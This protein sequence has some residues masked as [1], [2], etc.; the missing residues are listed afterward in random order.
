MEWSTKC[1][2]WES[3]VLKGESLITFPPLFPLEADSA[4]AVFKELRLVDVLNRPTLGEAGRQ[5]LFDFVGAIFGA[6]DPEGGRRLIQEFFLLISKKN[7]KSTGASAIMLTALIR[8]WRDSAEFLIL[9]PTV[10]IANN[11]F[12]PA[13]DMV[14]A[15]GELSDLFLVQ[16]HYRQITHRTT[17]AVLK[18]VAADSET[19]GGKKATGILIDEAWLM[20]KRA[21]AENMLRE[22]CGGLA[23]RPEGFIIYLSTQSDE[24]PAGVFKQMTPDKRWT[25]YQRVCDKMLYPT[26]ETETGR[27]VYH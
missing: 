26:A 27:V 20:G 23:S 25:I 5:W 24:A 12:Y 19:V 6:Y 2:D 18:V 16:E 15:D 14:K 11:S 22:A 13:R 10:E 4:L 7:S 21:N 17:G 8:N 9:A 3:R 1:L